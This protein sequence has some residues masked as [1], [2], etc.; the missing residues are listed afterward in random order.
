MGD[1]A[2]SELAELLR[3][4][5]EPVYEE[6]ERLVPVRSGRLRDSLRVTGGKASAFV[7]AGFARIP[8]AGVIHYGTTATSGRPSNIRAQP[9]LDDAADN[10]RGEVI[11]RA[12]K[13]LDEF[14]EE[15]I[16]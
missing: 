5:A 2:A 4:A 3:Y 10:K 11:E 9:F 1:A 7:R 16:R 6:A 14:I 15:T 8:Y 12:V 13:A